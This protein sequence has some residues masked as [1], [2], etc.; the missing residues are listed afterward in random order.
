LY[1]ARIKILVQAVGADEFKRMV[2]EEWSHIRDSALKLPEE[3]VARIREYFAPPEFETLAGPP[4]ELATQL[5]DEEEFASWHRQNVAIHRQLGFSVV[6]ISLKPEG[7]I[8]GDATADQMDAVADLA[9][10]FSFGEIRVTHEQNLVLAHVR[11]RDLF[12]LWVGLVETG[13]SAANLSLVTDVV[14]CPGLDYCGLATARSIPVAQHISKRF[15]E[16]QRARDIG[17]LRLNISGCINACG[18]HHAGN[19]GI[20]GVDKKN[21]E[22]YQITLG[23]H[24]EYDAS[25]GDVIGPAVPSSEVVDAVERIV[26][27]YI[28]VRTVDERFIDT[29]RRVGMKPFKEAVYAAH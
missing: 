22:F 3:E 17:E 19:I 24:G 2:E 9:D 21:Q 6:N 4:P 13:L 1:K 20:L 28:D 27:A 8:P 7:G 14:C 25:I 29:Y 5:E 12:S 26:D 23:G 16:L 10:Q 15:A 18:H 11:Q